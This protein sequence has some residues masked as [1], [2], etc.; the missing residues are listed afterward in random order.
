MKFKK[1][2]IYLLCAYLSAF[3]PLRIAY[4]APLSENTGAGGTGSSETT[5]D[6]GLGG[7]T[8]GEGLG[9]QTG[10]AN[11]DN[12]DNT[13]CPDSSLISGKLISN[14]CWTCLFP[15]IS[16]G[17]A[18]GGDKDEAPDDRYKNPF[19]LCK[20]NQGIP[21]PGFTYGLWMPAKA[22]EFVRQ[23]GCLS[24]LDGATLGFDRTAQGEWSQKD[25]DATDNSFAHYH[26][27]TFP[28]LIVLN[29]FERIECVK[30]HYVD[31]DILFLSE[32]DPTWS[33]DTIAFFTN[34]EAVIFGNPIAALACIPD[35]TSATF[36]QKPIQSLFW[37]AGSWGSMY[38]L[39]GNHASSYGGVHDSSLFTARMLTA[40]HRRGFLKT[41]YGEDALCDSSVTATLP[42]TQY[43]ITML[44]PVPETKS[45]HVIGEST[46]MWGAS[47][48]VPVTGEDFIYLIWTW[49]DC[50]MALI[51]SSQG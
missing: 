47:R 3:A 37:C 41:T 18:F 20:D 6:P 30:D 14:T 36:L 27:Y 32:V 1:F 16:M 12:I 50:C 17:M 23:P 31:I 39:T 9:S 5:V 22:V 24:M 33:D 44:Y 21:Y 34:P 35:A 29:M 28:L 4:S 42:K 19:C 25:H 49:N 48:Q 26:F 7:A 8:P 2:S 40:L 10:D 51:G 45:A 11:V 46:L 15:I 43:K 38:P 13:T